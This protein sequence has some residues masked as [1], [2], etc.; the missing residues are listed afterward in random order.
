[1]GDGNGG[2][3]DAKLRELIRRRESYV[4]S[5]RENQFEE[6]L[7]R[8]LTDLYPDNAHFIYEL[9]QNAEDA[10]DSADAESRGAT[11]V[12]FV[13]TE[14]AIE[15]EHDGSRLFTSENVES[16][17]SIGKS[18]KRNDPTTIGKF[19]VG[20]KAVFAYTDSPE[21]HSGLYDF[22]I[23]DM[24]VPELLP[25]ALH[26]GLGTRFVFPFNHP[27]KSPSKAV[28]EI[29]DGLRSLGDNTLLF[30]QHIRHIEYMLP[31]GSYGS[32]KRDDLDGGV[33]EI[34]STHPNEPPR[35]SRWLRFESEV[36][37]G[38]ERGDQK[39][40]RVAL[41]F[42]LKDDP[43]KEG[44]LPVRRIVPV[45]GQVSIF[46]PAEKETSQLRFHVHAP[47]ASTVA[48]DSIRAC[49]ANNELRDSI[50]ELLAVSLPK[51]RDLGL[52]SVEFLGTLP[53][54][55]DR[56]AA[57][58]E[59]LRKKAVDAFHNAD[60]TPTRNGKHAK[61]GALFA[62]PARI[63]EAIGDDDLEY[64]TGYDA[65]LWT[66]NAAQ[67][68]L[69]EQH[70]LNSLAIDQWGWSQ[71]AE[72][73]DA[74]EEERR[75]FIEAW[76]E[77]KSDP[78]ML[79]LYSLLGECIQSPHSLSIDVD[80]LR[81]VRVEKDEGH[82]HVVAGDAFFALN[83]E[84]SEPRRAPAGIYYVKPAVYQVGRSEQ[85]RKLAKSFLESIGV[86]LYDEKAVI[87]RML[88]RYRTAPP[89]Q[90]GPTYFKELRKFLFFWKANPLQIGLLKGVPFL[91]GVASEQL[92]W[93]SG[94]QLCIDS[95]F[96]DTG[97]A[98]FQNVHKLFPLWDGYITEFKNDAIA[99]FVEFVA[100]LGGRTK[101]DVVK[102]SVS[103]NPRCRELR[104]DYRGDV[105]TS[106]NYVNEDYWISDLGSYLAP[107]SIEGSLL[108]WNAMIHADP[109]V[110]TARFRPNSRFNTRIADSRLVHAL[111]EHAW[112]PTRNG[113]FAKPADV[114][115]GDI[116]GDFHWSSTNGLLAKI[117]FAESARRRSQEYQAKSEQA[118][119][120]GFSSAE[121][122]ES[123]AALVREKGVTFEEIESLVS[124][125][126]RALQPEGVIR[127]PERRRRVVLEERS[128][129]PLKESVKRERTIQAGLQEDVL[130]ARAYLRS[131]YTNVDRDLVCQVCGLAMPFRVG[132]LHYF[133]AV[134]CIRGL[135]QRF[136]ENR[137]ALCPTCAA[138]YQYARG[139]EFEE[140]R[141][142]IIQS[143]AEA[144]V[145]AVEI[146]V[147]LA[148]V[149]RTLR[150]VADH[151]LDLK[152]VL[153]EPGD[154]VGV[155]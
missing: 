145:G 97:L 49:G 116:R 92:K 124:K 140:I 46:F 123:L 27:E 88:R 138:M 74:L 132:D 151:W 137:L 84:G 45:D 35:V 73:F 68:Q 70:F 20:F 101:L 87:E 147:T 148:G 57:F 81:L 111:R 58:Y 142:R 64:L 146:E 98:E 83:P 7:R 19:G 32:L 8:L 125:H 127:N 100:A 9:L 48:R 131:K 89:Q 114:C 85:Q 115:D 21:V 36:E 52:L 76:I 12:R 78:W 62:G 37:V 34:S 80:E 95:P 16:I 53:I 55:E 17:T 104:A 135:P 60:L 134:Q 42:G 11:T 44:G 110:A 56:L 118:R 65:P 69:R 38:D 24:V 129:A 149:E 143:P 141:Q 107:P 126:R 75:P 96:K 41:A 28:S 144:N 94:S 122:A 103:E 26:S 59:P 14:T 152:T 79:R 105:R 72:C 13:L 71:L 121:E 33:I 136:Y 10:R 93:A 113:E 6:G 3:D 2:T 86:R 66:A 128:N 1:M 54:P 154:V 40:C 130:Q 63:A 30:L 5:L 23:R 4:H 50:A 153:E 106:S 139:T 29:E 91:V 119:S 120:M 112:V 82:D 22:R 15:V 25:R 117:G 39:V 18:S 51:I 155:Q 43:L 67:Q 77:K 150:F 133:E 108:I 31:D 99:S 109:K 47:F 61:A 90:P 102:T